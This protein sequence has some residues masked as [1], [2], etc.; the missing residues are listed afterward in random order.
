MCCRNRD[1][2]VTQQVLGGAKSV[3]AID[4]A[5]EL[6]AQFVNRF[7]CAN[8]RELYRG[9]VFHCLGRK[10][11]LRS[12]NKRIRRNLRC[13]Q[14]YRIVASL[15]DKSAFPLLDEPFSAILDRGT[16]DFDE[17]LDPNRSERNNNRYG[18]EFDAN[19]VVRT[20][21]VGLCVPNRT[22]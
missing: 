3:L 8:S 11:T 9:Q 16:P 5:A 22:H 6:F 14:L 18:S 21:D 7:L 17:P 19:R 2:G 4:H 10:Q 13:P 12:A 20:S 15:R 1:V